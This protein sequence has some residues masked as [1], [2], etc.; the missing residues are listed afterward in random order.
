MEK[1]NYFTVDEANQQIPWL[2]VRLREIISLG[3]NIKRLRLQ[4][5]NILRVGSSNGHTDIDQDVSNHR[6][7]IGGAMERL[8]NLVLDINTSGMILKDIEMGLVDFPTIREDREVYL[9][10]HLGEASTQFWHETDVGFSG[11]QPLV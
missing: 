9:C 8:R 10:W 7:E 4:L 1:Q 5:D 2:R 3:K 11:R 6:K